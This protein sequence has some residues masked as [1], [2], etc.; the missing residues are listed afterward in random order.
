[1]N[2]YLKEL[3]YNNILI[4]NKI[5]NWRND[6]KTRLFSNNSNIITNDIFL[7]IIEK[8]KESGVI[9][10]IIYLDN[11]EVGVLSFVKNNNN[12][13]I[14]IN[15]DNEYRNMKIG[16]YAIEEFIKLNNNDMIY[17]SIKKENLSSIKLF[18]KYFKY[19]EENENYIEYYLKI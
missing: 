3:D 18:S 2:I 15:I 6:E 9:P 5:F 12:I 8:Y 7:K 17:A 13:Y 10:L 16:T 19:F 14:G 1:M 11:K 4:L